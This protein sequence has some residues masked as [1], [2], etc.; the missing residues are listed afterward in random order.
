NCLLLA[1]KGYLSARHQLDL[2]YSK[3][4]E[5]QTPMRKNQHDYRPW[6]KTFKTARRRIETVFSQLCDQMMF[7]RNYAKTFA[8]LRTRIISKVTA[9]NLLQYINKQN[10]RPVNH[11]KH[12]LA[13]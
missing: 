5:L 2:F 9:M 10:G 7:K 12:A 1:D 6:P 13:T 8:G 4:I 3:G 11:I